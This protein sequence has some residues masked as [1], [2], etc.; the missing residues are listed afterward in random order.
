[1]SFNL[2]LSTVTDSVSRTYS[3]GLHVHVHLF[4]ILMCQITNFS[5]FFSC[6]R[7]HLHTGSL[8]H[9]YCSLA[10]PCNTCTWP[11]GLLNS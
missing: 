8:A 1:V 4:L 6:S 3:I 10:L 7:G 11:V 2:K 9:L 5:P